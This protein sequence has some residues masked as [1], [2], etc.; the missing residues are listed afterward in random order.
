MSN[1]NYQ[2]EHELTR[3]DW[4]MLADAIRWYEQLGYLYIEVPYAVPKDIIRLT[5]PPEYDD[6]IQPVEPYGCLVGSSEQSLLHL[7]LPHGDY[8]ACSPCFRPE[9]VLNDLYQ[10]HFMK[11]ELFQIGKNMSP[12]KMLL[13]AQGFMDGF[14]TT[15]VLHTDQGRDLT[16]AGIEVG[17]YGFREADGRTWACGTGLALPRFD[18][19]RQKQIASRH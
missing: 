7:D 14:A 18:V 1:P 19:A 9:P 10:Y 5:L 11:V 3:I 12:T 4:R 13:D 17:S 8:V 15:E 16:V 6:A 2:W